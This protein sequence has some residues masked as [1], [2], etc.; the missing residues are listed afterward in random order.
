MA[1][2]YTV[3]GCMTPGGQH[4]SQR[5]MIVFGTALYYNTPTL[6]AIGPRYGRCVVHPALEC[7]QQQLYACVLCLSS[8]DTWCGYGWRLLLPGLDGATAR[9]RLSMATKLLL[10]EDSLSIQ[11]IVETTFAREGFEVMVAGDALDGLRKA[12]TLQPDIVLADASMPDMDGFQLCQSIRQSAGSRHVPVVL[13]TSGFAAYDKAKGDHA[14][15]TMHLAKPF[16][17]QVLLDMVKQ[18]VPGAHRPASPV[19]AIAPLL[20]R[21]E[22][23]PFETPMSRPQE[24]AES[25]IPLATIVSMER[26]DAETV[27]PSG[28]PGMA[29][30][31]LG[32]PRRHAAIPATPPEVS[33]TAEPIPRASDAAFPAAS[34][35]AQDAHPSVSRET[36]SLNVLYQTLGCHMVQMLREA[37]EAQLPTMLAQLMPHLL[38]TVRDVV[39]AKMPDLLEVLLQQEIDKLKQAVEQDQHDA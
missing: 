22:G 4:V 28:E 33:H 25:A 12:Q 39:Q 20:P 7:R 1:C 14:G 24:H 18:L 3:S 13:L 37:L 29:G 31:L 27:P 35:A 23:D 6:W 21:P 38:D 2:S 19:S 32:D 17:P 16:E 9:E 26:V 5:L 10:V 8:E 11:T 30:E 34:Q 36:V 15:V